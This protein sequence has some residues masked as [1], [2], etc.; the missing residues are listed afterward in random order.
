MKM[1]LSV[2]TLLV[3]V[4]LR[5]HAKAV[6]DADWFTFN[7]PPD[8]FTESPIDLRSLNEKFAGEHGFIATRGDEFMH[9]AS[10]EPVRF[11]E[12]NGPPTHHRL[13]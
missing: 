6:A 3:S 2:I 9:S 8:A 11:W 10:H 4:L 5:C 13:G 1:K 12:V 7:P